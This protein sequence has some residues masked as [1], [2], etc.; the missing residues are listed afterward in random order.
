MGKVMLGTNWKMHKTVRESKQ[1]TKKLLDFTEKY[2]NIQFFIIPPYTNLWH[3][4]EMINNSNMFIGA[5]NMHYKSEGPFTGEIS[6]KMLKEIDLDIV[7]LG[8]SERRQYYNENDYEINKKVLTSLNYKF[9]PLICIGEN[10][11]EKNYKITKEKLRMQVKITL[12]DVSL[13]DVRKVWLAYE[14]IWAIGKGGIPATPEYAEEA[15]GY[16]REILVELYGSEIANEVPLLY[17][18]SVNPENA[19]SLIKRKNIDGLF[20]GR[21][22]W[23]LEQFFQIIEMVDNHIKTM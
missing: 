21:S 16:I 15:H 4:K 8:H 18:G 7:Q 1:Y 3:V 2:E 22:A 12:K 11:E 14:P 17:G 19:L 13:E 20:I 5:Q 9:T 23:D 6:P 10:I